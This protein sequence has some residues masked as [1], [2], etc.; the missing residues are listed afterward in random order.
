MESE[1]RKHL[2]HNIIANLLDGGFFGLAFG[3]ASFV[4]VIPLFVSTLTDSALLIGLIP[5]IH[6]VGWQLPQILIAN[7]VSHLRSYRSM[8][9][10]FTLQERL[11]ILIL[12][13]VAWKSSDIGKQ[14]ALILV[15]L[16][17]IWQGL[18]AG[19][20]AAPWQS[21]IGKIIPADRRGT[22][23]GV[24][25][26]AANFLASLSAVLAGYILDRYNSNIG[27]AICFFLASVFLVIS[28]VFMAQTREPEHDVS[29]D[30]VSRGD[31]WAKVG[32]ILRT[33]VNFRWFLAVRMLSQLSTM[34][35]AFYTVYAVHK[36]GMS[37]FTVGVMTSVF[38]GAQI[39]ASPLMGWLGDRWSH[40]A[41]M[42]IG[43]ASAAASGLLA[44]LA[45]GPT[46]F[47]LVFTLA[48]IANVALWTIALAM[49]LEFGAPD[50]RPSYIGLA[51]SLVAP[52]TFI[53]PLIG[54]ILATLWGYPAA[55]I[56][57]SIGAVSTAL[58]L[59]FLVQDPKKIMGRR[60]AEA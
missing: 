14:G 34:G 51:N 25:S 2:R 40:R 9:V 31:F 4:T 24:Q 43:L 33:D 57:S 54:G 42:E 20:T 59:H 38:L 53:A 18:G 35:S 19:F 10:V 15:F 30:P 1:V 6:A 28:W 32:Q 41:L 52:A 36:L 47:Y 3:F 13:L 5:A 11:P 56:A 29:G 16:L 49:I 8:V 22:F 37:E 21:M 17:L 58:M 48:G 26:A 45:P 55:F 44:W 7:R 50:D 39:V 27:F 12:A 46:W 23:Y 60:P